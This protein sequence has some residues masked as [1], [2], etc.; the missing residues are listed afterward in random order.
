M[1]YED[2]VEAEEGK[3]KWEVAH[4]LQTSSCEQAERAERYSSCSHVG[5]YSQAELKKH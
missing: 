1:T 2:V 5:T 4:G 3:E